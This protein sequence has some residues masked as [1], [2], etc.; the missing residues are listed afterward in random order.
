MSEMV[1][2]FEESINYIYEFMK[3]APERLKELDRLISNLEQEECDIRHYI[4]FATYNASEGYNLSIELKKLLKERRLYKNEKNELHSIYERFSSMIG[5]IK[6]VESLKKGVDKS[7][8][9]S[10]KA[11]V[12]IPRI[13]V[14]LF[15]KLKQKGF[16][17]IKFKEEL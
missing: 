6:K 17:G 10:N 8:F 16:E 9:E 3:K 7:I 11:K 5:G 4:E 12:Y 14:D 13:R 2:R 1:D 15:E